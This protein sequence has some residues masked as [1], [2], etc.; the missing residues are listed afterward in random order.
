M[1]MQRFEENQETTNL[2]EGLEAF[3][4]PETW[5]G[6]PLVVAFHTKSPA[7][8]TFPKQH[9]EMELPSTLVCSAASLIE[10]K[11]RITAPLTGS[12][13]ATWVDTPF[14]IFHNEPTAVGKSLRA[15]NKRSVA[16]VR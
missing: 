8:L 5:S 3:I 4:V 13:C 16:K 7:V 11:T 10:A 14:G 6:E 2:L 1:A 12:T 15:V 9:F